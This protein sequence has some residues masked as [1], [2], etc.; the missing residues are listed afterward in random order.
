MTHN[1]ITNTITNFNYKSYSFGN[2]RS[3]K[4]S[5]PRNKNSTRRLDRVATV[6]NDSKV[7]EENYGQVGRRIKT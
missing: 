6:F 1:T 4:L 2:R 7:F 3:L 5:S